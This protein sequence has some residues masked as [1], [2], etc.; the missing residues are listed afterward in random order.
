MSRSAGLILHPT[1]LPGRFGIGDLG[2]E[3]EKFLD[4]AAS[5]GQRL[6]Q[7]LPLHPTGPGDSPYGA[8]SAFAG[9]PLLLSPERL[10]EE[11]MVSRADLESVPEFPRDR[12]DY[13]S[14][15]SW[16]E[17][18]LRR[19]WERFLARAGAREELETFRIAPE[20]APWLS[21]WALFA[22]LKTRLAGPWTSWREGLL[23]RRPDAALKRSPWFARGDNSPIGN[24]IGHQPDSLANCGSWEWDRMCWWASSCGWDTNSRPLASS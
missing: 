18:L 1:S 8:S 10:F 11:D 19:S 22:A 7:I 2:P 9:N 15:R 4:W 16:K 17:K 21:D 14:V 6:W 12:V 13:A 23:R 20:W 5:A 24:W 3:A